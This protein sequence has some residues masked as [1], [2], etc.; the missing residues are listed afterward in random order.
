MVQKQRTYPT[1]CIARGAIPTNMCHMFNISWTSYLQLP[2][3]NNCK[4][5]KHF[6][7]SL[8][9]NPKNTQIPLKGNGITK[10]TGDIFV[11]P[12]HFGCH[13]I[14]YKAPKIQVYSA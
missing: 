11:N 4:L 1:G 6:C 3:L 12:L 2:L 13:G 7:L 5:Q 14:D 8:K 9:I 10:N